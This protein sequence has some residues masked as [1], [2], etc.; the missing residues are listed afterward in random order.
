MSII[1]FYINHNIL[2]EVIYTSY[3]TETIYSQRY[4]GDG[5]GG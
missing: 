3:Q 4:N 1:G 2:Q 5:I